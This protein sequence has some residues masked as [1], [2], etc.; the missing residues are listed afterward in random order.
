[1]RNIPSTVVYPTGPWFLSIFRDRQ[2]RKVSRFPEVSR[3][4]LGLWT[5]RRVE[6]KLAD[7]TQSVRGEAKLIGEGWRLRNPRSK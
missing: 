1:M 2:C 7:G 5:G 6:A 4:L 3:F